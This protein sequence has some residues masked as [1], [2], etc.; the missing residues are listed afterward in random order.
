M[1]KKTSS[2]RYRIVISSTFLLSII[3]ITLFTIRGNSNITNAKTNN[4]KAKTETDNSKSQ[5]EKVSPV[6][7][8]KAKEIKTVQADIEPSK[9][10]YKTEVQLK[11]YKTTIDRYKSLLHSPQRQYERDKLVREIAK[12]SGQIELAGKILTSNKLATSEFGDEQAHSR[13]IAIDILSM[14]AEEGDISPLVDT[15]KV[16]GKQIGK[17]TPPNV[18]SQFDYRDCVLK[19]IKN[20][21]P[22]DFARDLD[23]HL[24]E[25]GYTKKLKK[26]LLRAI[27]FTYGENMDRTEYKKLFGKLYKA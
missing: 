23:Y 15:I 20:I 14:S 1:N 2:K 7:T 5:K 21:G 19:Y 26:P 24:K 3:L 17:G 10:E 11:A 8:S 25:I 18:G 9:A 16:L 12:D 6:S 13:V 22:H 27:F 4:L